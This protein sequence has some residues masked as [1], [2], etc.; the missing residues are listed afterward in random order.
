MERHIK[1]Q[2]GDDC[3]VTHRVSYPFCAQVAVN[4]EKGK[5]LVGPFLLFCP[6]GVAESICP[7]S[8]VDAGYTGR[9]AKEIYH[10]IASGESAP[11]AAK[12]EQ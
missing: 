4:G 8:C 10:S 5:L 9:E 12:M 1:E 3:I 2:L 7:A 11:V 6:C